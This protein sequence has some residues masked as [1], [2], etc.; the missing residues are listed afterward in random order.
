[1][2][3]EEAAKLK[4]RQLACGVTDL[5]PV[6]VRELIDM[7]KGIED[8]EARVRAGHEET[9]HEAWAATETRE[10]HS[11]IPGIDRVRAY[12]KAHFGGELCVRTAELLLCYLCRHCN[13]IVEAEL[14]TLDEAVDMLEPVKKLP[15]GRRSRSAKDGQK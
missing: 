12:V 2:M 5:R 6:K 11:W 3:N 7:L 4:A 10:R 8:H 9:F 13:S 14:L 15:G 1:M